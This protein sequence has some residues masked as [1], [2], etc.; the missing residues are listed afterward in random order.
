[1]KERD[2]ELNQRVLADSISIM[3]DV[4]VKPF[5]KEKVER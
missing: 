3:E 2:A 4:Y 1:M 5:Q